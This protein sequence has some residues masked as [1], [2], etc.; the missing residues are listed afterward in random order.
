MF[1]Q[2]LGMKEVEERDDWTPHWQELFDVLKYLN[3]LAFVEQQCWKV[4]QYKR[5]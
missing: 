1:L 4:T 3:K 2:R 5:P